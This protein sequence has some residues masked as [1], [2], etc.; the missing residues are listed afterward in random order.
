MK[1]TRFLPSG[2]KK[3]V[4][5]GVPEAPAPVAVVAA[6]P[7]S[8]PVPV[9]VVANARE[10]LAD[11]GLDLPAMKEGGKRRVIPPLAS[12]TLAAPLALARTLRHHGGQGEKEI[13]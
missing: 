8:L 11:A 9:L 4:S 10:A 12:T 7:L 6:E 5:V 1:S 13:S 3:L 2:I